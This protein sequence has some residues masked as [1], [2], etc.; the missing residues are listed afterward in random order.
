MLPFCCSKIAEACCRFVA[1]GFLPNYTVAGCCY[2]H[3][4]SLKLDMLVVGECYQTALAA[5]LLDGASNILTRSMLETKLARPQLVYLLHYC[6]NTHTSS[7][8]KAKPSAPS[9]ML[10]SIQR[11]CAAANLLQPA[12]PLPRF[13][14]C[15]APR[16]AQCCTF[17]GCSCC[18]HGHTRI[19]MSLSKKT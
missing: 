19:R 7:Q 11:L 14:A 16:F 15:S 9:K 13:A 3:M 18:H 5:G 6:T 4:T 1:R 8:K 2:T 12:H 17:H 10:H